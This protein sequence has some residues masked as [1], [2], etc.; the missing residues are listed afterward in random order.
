MPPKPV[1]TY[2]QGHGPSTVASHQSRSAAK[3]AGYLLSHITPTSHILDVGCG[4]G[5]ITCDFAALAHASTVIGV[6]YSDDV[7]ATARNE[8]SKRG[9]SNVDFQSGSAFEL[10]FE[11]GTFDVVHCHALLVHLPNAPAAVKE[12]RRVLKPNGYLGMREPDWFTCVIHPPYPELTRWINVQAEL[13]RRE[14]AE[15]NAGR[16]LA[17]WCLESGF[18]GG[19]IEVRCDVLSYS[20]EE[21]IGWWGELYAKRMGTE[22]GKR[23]VETG[24][25]TEEEVEGWREGYL[26]WARE[27]GEKGGI[28]A[29]MHMKVLARK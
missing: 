17:E 20:G 8:A 14:G 29:M 4:P 2:I 15:P 10:P 9:L 1:T 21:E 23:A 28:W 27:G 5:T 24:L 11:D 13:K 3:Q 6:D 18:E 16:H 12:M 19:R 22:V 7:L 26:R 25:A